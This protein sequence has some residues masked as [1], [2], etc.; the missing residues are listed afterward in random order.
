MSN[1]TF[2]H[3]SLSAMGSQGNSLADELFFDHLI[4]YNMCTY[5]IDVTYYRIALCS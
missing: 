1:P 5:I 3:I 2:L 4:Y